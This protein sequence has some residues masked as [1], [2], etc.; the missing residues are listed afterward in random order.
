MIKVAP[1]LFVLFINFFSYSQIKFEKGY[2]IDNS[3]ERTNCLIKNID[4]KNNPKNFKYKLSE[5][6]TVKDALIT[7]VSEFSI[8]NG[9]KYKRY[10]V[11]IDRS[12]D[13]LHN[14]TKNR[15]SEWSEESLFLKVLVE[16][17]VT[18]YS[19]E[20]GNLKKFFFS[21][22]NIIPKQLIYK[23]YLSSKGDKATNYDFRQQL[24]DY[25]NCQKLSINTFKKINYK[26]HNLIDHFIENNTCENSEITFSKKI[27]TKS[28][29][30]FKIK[31]G[32]NFSSLSIENI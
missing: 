19:Y 23:Y 28:L 15:N 24:I 22:N 16:G 10:L 31:S 32:L 12:T 25:V 20:E 2:F 9:A 3:G 11:K 18:L 14:M 5:D 26:Q 4:W 27:Q 1:I 29:V 21:N 8:E 7:E 17:K 6:S 30:N 13:E